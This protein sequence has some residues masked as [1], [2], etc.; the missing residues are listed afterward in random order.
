M[1]TR[2]LVCPPNVPTAP[3]SDI[4]RQWHRFIEAVTCASDV[5]VIDMQPHADLPSLTFTGS[6]ALV[7]TGMAIV[8]SFRQPERR[9]EQN[10]FRTAL[11]GAGLATTYLRQTYFEGAADALLDHTRGLC[12]LGYGW[13]TE[14]SAA[15]LLQELLSYR[16]LPLMLTDVRFINLNQVLCP[17]TSGHVLAYMHAFSPHAQASL[18]R[19][20]NAEYLI[21]VGIEDALDLA[22]NAIELGMNTLVLHRAS[23]Q[24]RGRLNDIGYRLFCTDLDAFI[25]LGGSAKSLI[26]QLDNGESGAE[27]PGVFAN[28]AS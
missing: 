15:I 25:P 9:R 11:A 17:L 20:I 8:S 5:S 2:L 1:S 28:T 26:L 12:Y 21:E 3:C 24:L 6:A 7:T 14:R 13:H 27:S 19:T 4:Q 10:I 22:C 23:R 16:V 18:R